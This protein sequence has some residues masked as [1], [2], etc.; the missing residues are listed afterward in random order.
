MSF[1]TFLIYYI[2]LINIVYSNYEIEVNI[3]GE[4]NIFQYNDKSK[5]NILEN[6]LEW[7]KKFNINTEECARMLSHEVYYKEAIL[8]YNKKKIEKSENEIKK[9]INFINTSIFFSSS[10]K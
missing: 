2:F 5:L 7:C 8:S 1:Y 3:D 9:A 10:S 4:I 6:S